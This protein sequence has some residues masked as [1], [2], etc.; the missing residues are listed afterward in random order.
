MKFHYVKTIEEALILAFPKRVL[1]EDPAT[2]PVK[3]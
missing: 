2:E 1:N 3:A